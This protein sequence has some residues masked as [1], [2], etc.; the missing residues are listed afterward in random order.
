MNRTLRDIA[1]P[2]EGVVADGQD[3]VLKSQHEV[4]DSDR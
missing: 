4:H 3:D 2:L 1:H